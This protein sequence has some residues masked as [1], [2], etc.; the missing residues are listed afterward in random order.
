VA[1]PPLQLTPASE[2]KV[3]GREREISSGLS[4]FQCLEKTGQKVPRVW[5]N[6]Q[7]IPSKN[8][9]RLVERGLFVIFCVFRG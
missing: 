5:E 7:I 2:Q 6:Y 4:D 3:E 8:K 9:P 1:D